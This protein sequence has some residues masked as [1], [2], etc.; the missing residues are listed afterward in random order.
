MQPTMAEVWDQL[1]LDDKDM[2]IAMMIVKDIPVTMSK[3][4]FYKIQTVISCLEDSRDKG[5]PT[6]C[7][8]SICVKYKGRGKKVF[9]LLASVARKAG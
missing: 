7:S 8:C 2:I 4:A 6:N 1:D 3:L 5:W 9:D